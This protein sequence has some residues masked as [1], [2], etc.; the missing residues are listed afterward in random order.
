MSFHFEI[1]DQL[2]DTTYSFV[3]EMFLLTFRD[4]N[5][6]IRLEAPPNSFTFQIKDVHGTIFLHAGD[7]G[8]RVSI[9]TALP[10]SSYLI[11]IIGFVV[12]YFLYGV[13]GAFIGVFFAG[14]I[15]LP[16]FVLTR[17][18]RRTTLGVIFCEALQGSNFQ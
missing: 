7:P 5:A 12:F 17:I 9:T 8:T 10:P 15:F 2:S 3:K 18:R 11:F 16:M 6:E 14:I 4:K 13:I 1:P